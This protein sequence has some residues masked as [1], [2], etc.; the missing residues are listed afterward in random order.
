MPGRLFDLGVVAA[1]L[2][3]GAVIAV[4]TT[5]EFPRLIPARIPY[6]LL[7]LV[8][9]ATLLARRRYP[10]VSFAVILV[11]LV[12]ET[13][14]HTVEAAVP[15]LLV[16]VYTIAYRVDWRISLPS[17][18]GTLVLLISASA[19]A[20]GGGPPA[21]Q[22][23]SAMVTI[24]GAFLVGLYVRTRVSYIESLQLRT[25]QLDRERELLADRAVAE[26]RVRIAREL[27]DV[28]AHHLSLITVQ[29]GALEVQ[30]PPGDPARETAVSMARSGRKAMDEMRLMLGVLRLGAAAQ[31][32]RT[33]QPGIVDIPQLV[34]TARAGGLDVRL[35]YAGGSHH[36]PPGIDLS[37]YRIV[38]EALTNVL[39]HAGPAHC[40][41]TV[42]C[43]LDRLEVSITDDGKGGA[44]GES[45]SGIGHGLVGMRERVALFGGNLIAGR[46]PA[47]GYAVRATFPLTPTGARQ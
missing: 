20:R 46:V 38:Q 40:T 16:G 44:A 9:L 8:P 7:V 17:A 12:L 14:L 18:A 42:R 23:V 13:L 30:L 3:I 31:P 33:P 21:Q 4:S 35:E 34:E 19:I 45:P 2:V 22:A 25:E 11:S 36:I 37:A 15:L 32:E 41:V 27:H 5:N 43:A 47:G 6:Y 29:A 26:E 10:L 39:R 28:V 1:L 24:A